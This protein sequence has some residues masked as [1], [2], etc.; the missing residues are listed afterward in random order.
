MNI[1]FD[2]IGQD[3]VTFM[4]N[5][6]AKAGAVVKIGAN[7][8]VSGCSDGDNFAGFALNI[9]DYTAAVV[10]HG[11][12]TVPYTG[13]AP[14]F[15]YTTVAANG[16]GGVK[17]ASNGRSVIVCNVDTANTTVGMFI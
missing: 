11:Y 7:N 12:V 8:I 6:S 3:V 5:G 4:A 2:G 16:T 17:A 9:E 10:I 13:T 15:G 1:C 14:A